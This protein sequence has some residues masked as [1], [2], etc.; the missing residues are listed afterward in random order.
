MK[1]VVITSAV[2]TPIGRLGGALCDIQPEELTRVVIEAAIKR[3][4]LAKDQIDEV[5]IGQ[6][7]QTTDAPNIARVAALMAGIPES[8]PAYTVHRQCSSGLQ[9]IINAVW[10]IQAGYAD[11]AV[12]GGVES[13]SLAPYYLRK[14]RFGYQSGNGELIDPNTESQPKSQPEDIYGSF[15][16]GLTAE[17]LAEIYHIAREEQDSFACSSQHKAAAAIDSGRFKDE[18]APVLIDRKKDTFTFD[19]D[20][21]QRR[22]TSLEKLAKLKP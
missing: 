13:M 4:F 5:I 15:N 18:I 1:K 10:Q 2:R 8:V 11:V 20:E 22:D 9:S 12:A 14:A 21:H 16:M 17:N 7:K 3:S 19:T 6:T